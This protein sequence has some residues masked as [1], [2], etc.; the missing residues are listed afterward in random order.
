M[1]HLMLSFTCWTKSRLSSSDCNYFDSSGWFWN[2]LDIFF[3]CVWSYPVSERIW[4][5][6]THTK[7]KPQALYSFSPNVVLGHTH[8]KEFRRKVNQ[9][10]ISLTN[11][12]VP[13]GNLQGLDFVSYL[14]TN[15][16][17]SQIFCSGKWKLQNK[18]I[19]FCVCRRGCLHWAPPLWG[20]SFMLS[21]PSVAIILY[22]GKKSVF[23]R[24][25][26]KRSA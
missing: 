3:S 11:F 13:F 20:L 22:R 16:N 25:A 21:H 12:A 1:K 26:Y 15:T 23:Y 18:Q 19:F 17:I 2:K 6:H 9:M 7:P 10:L 8:K 5:K 14:E 24:S 4:F